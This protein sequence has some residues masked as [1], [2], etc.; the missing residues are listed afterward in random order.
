LYD[1]L[2]FGALKNVFENDRTFVLT[3]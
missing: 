3:P 1:R 2:F